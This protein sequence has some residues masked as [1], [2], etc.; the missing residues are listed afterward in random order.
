M[1]H[2]NIFNVS[3]FLKK[4]AKEKTRLEVYTKVRKYTLQ[5][6]SLKKWQNLSY[7]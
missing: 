5:K 4:S 1:I 7:K 6:I 2:T 3:N